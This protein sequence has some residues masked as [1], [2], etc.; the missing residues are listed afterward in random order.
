MVKQE[1]NI[2]EQNPPEKTAP[3]NEKAKYLKY[4]DTKG[5]IDKMHELEDK[6]EKLLVEEAQIKDREYGYL[7]SEC[8]ELKNLE[9][10]LWVNAEGTNDAQRKS[11]LQRQR[12]E[13][14][15]LMAIL[16]RS[17][18]ANFELENKRIEIDMAKKRLEGVRA[19]LELKTAQ[20]KY[21]A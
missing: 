14:N 10:E 19:V 2:E 18:N 3:I 17:K 15:E 4:L 16:L 20:L 12:K 7:G 13:N 8:S 9:A 6:L 5:L 11:W 21:L 1:Q